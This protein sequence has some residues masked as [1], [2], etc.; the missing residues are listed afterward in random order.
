MD[1]KKFRN[2]IAERL[3]NLLYNSKAKAFDYIKL[4]ILLSSIVALGLM[5]YAY[6]FEPPEEELLVIF[7]G[8]DIIFGVFVV[9]FMIRWLYA[10]RKGYFLKNNYGEGILMILILIYMVSN[11]IF[12]KMIIEDFVARIGFRDYHELSRLLLVMGL[13]FVLLFEFVKVGTGLSRYQLKPST[14]FIGSFILLIFLGTGLLMLPAATTQPGSMP[15]IKALFTA[16]S[17]SCVTGLIVV[18]TATYFTIKGQVV[19][20]ILMQLGGLSIVSFASFFAIFL[21]KSSGL[22]HQSMMKDV[23]S[24]ESLLTAKDLLKQIITITIIIELLSFFLIFFTWGNIEFN[25]IWKKIFFSAFHAISAFCNAGFSLFSNGLY[26]PVV[27]EAYLLHIVIIITVI[28]GGIGF[29]SIQDLFYPS[30]L[31]DRLKNPWKDWKTST[32]IAVYTSAALLV[33]G[34]LIFLILERNHSMKDLN[35]VEA[36]ITSFFQS[37]TTRTAGFNTVD[38]GSLR[39]P[40]LLIFIFL[41]FIGGAS[42]SVAGGIKTSTFYLIVV[43]VIATIRGKLKIEIGKRYIPTSVLFKALSIFVFA[44]TANFIGIFTLVML[45]PNIPFMQLAFE[46]ISAF[47]TVGLST[48]ITADLSNNSLIVIMLSMFIGRV[49]TLTF[50]LALS[51]RV[52]TTAYKYPKAYIMAG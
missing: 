3:N 6:G 39:L 28:F 50:A 46:Q 49:G 34:T 33:F 7:I 19:I 9:T 16:V 25:S 47:G 1:S 10:F 31:R 32:K 44:A 40:T 35:F 15:L 29:S 51:T 38:I 26:E 5:L 45:E 22:K 24:S 8:L 42:G 36:A 48:G 18:D 11:Y 30:V 4:I 21:K 14:T 12:G 2:L 13:L 37:G 41:M 27:R 23:L 43:S 17:A 20:M 52:S